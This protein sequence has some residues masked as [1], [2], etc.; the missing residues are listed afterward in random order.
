MMPDGNRCSNAGF[1]HILKGP[2]IGLALIAFQP[3]QPR[4]EIWP[5]RHP[6]RVQRHRKPPT[7]G[8]DECLL[9]CPA[10]KKCC[11]ADLRS[12]RFDLACLGGCEE[13]L[14]ELPPVEVGTYGFGINTDCVLRTDSYEGKMPGV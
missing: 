5:Y 7:V 1:A 10:R 6:K 14:A 3:N 2:L 9:S 11:Y 4:R 8:L 13:P 12:K